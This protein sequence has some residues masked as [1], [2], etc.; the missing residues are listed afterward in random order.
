MIES[1]VNTKH[2]GDISN[3]KILT[4]LLGLGYPVLTPFGDNQRY[5]LVFERDGKFFKVQ[6]KTGRLSKGAI[7]FAASNQAG[8]GG[9]RRSYKGQI[10]YFGVYCPELRASFL[11][12]AEDV[13]NQHGS[14]RVEYPRNNQLD[15]V[16]WAKDYAL[17]A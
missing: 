9:P 6:S 12:P 17:A 10:D 2:V 8:G 16:R 3:S 7:V 1:D 14:L 15:G 13:G 5:D 4:A 11:V